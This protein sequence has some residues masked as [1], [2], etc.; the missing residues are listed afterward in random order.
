[1]QRPPWNK[2]V[3]ADQALPVWNTDLVLP[4]CSEVGDAE[5]VRPYPTNMADQLE[6]MSTAEVAELLGVPASTVRK[7]VEHGDL[8]TVPVGGNH[9]YHRGEVVSLRDQRRRVA[10]A[11]AA[12]SATVTTGAAVESPVVTVL[13]SVTRLA[14][15]YGATV[16]LTELAAVAGVTPEALRAAARRGDLPG[17]RKLGAEWRVTITGVCQLLDLPVPAR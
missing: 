17:A 12:A 3:N 16:P 10:E 15:T 13:A 4:E 11:A 1:M 8:T 5:A 2:P 6:S 14:A 7:L 9:R